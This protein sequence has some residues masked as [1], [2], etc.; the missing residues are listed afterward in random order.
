MQ[1]FDKTPSFHGRFFAVFVSFLEYNVGGNSAEQKPAINKIN[2]IFV[3]RYTIVGGFKP[4]EKYWSNWIISPSRDENKKYLKP[5]PSISQKFDKTEKCFPNHDIHDVQYLYRIAR[6][7]VT[8]QQMGGKSIVRQ[9]CTWFQRRCHLPH[10]QNIG[11]DLGAWVFLSSRILACEW[12]TIFI[13]SR[14]TGWCSTSTLL[15][16]FAC[17]FS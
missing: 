9:I 10:R 8:L 6:V 12:L 16:P 1:P 17:H 15:R 5:P 13:E 11:R 4:S 2:D 3:N 7:K 14:T